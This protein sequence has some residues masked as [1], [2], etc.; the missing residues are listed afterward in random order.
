[1][2]A[3]QF[4]EL[5]AVLVMHLPESLDHEAQVAWTLVQLLIPYAKKKKKNFHKPNFIKIVD[6]TKVVEKYTRTLNT[7]YY[8]SLF[9]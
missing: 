8:I 6:C 4:V 7:W 2:E 5:V 3:V 1:M 9:D